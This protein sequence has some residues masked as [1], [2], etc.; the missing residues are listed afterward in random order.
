MKKINENFVVASKRVLKRIVPFANKTQK[1]A[2]VSLLHALNNK[3]SQSQKMLEN[4]YDLWLKYV[5][6]YFH[7]S[8]KFETLNPEMDGIVIAFYADLANDYKKS[9]RKNKHCK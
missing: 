9:F 5:D 1:E 6:L 8:E 3:T 7:K 4:I 2:M